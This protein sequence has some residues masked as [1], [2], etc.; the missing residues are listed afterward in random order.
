MPTEAHKD[1][2]V[3]YCHVSSFLKITQQAFGGAQAGSLLALRVT[4]VNDCPR[5]ATKKTSP[6]ELFP[7]FN[8]SFH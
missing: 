6:G 1:Q 7:V 4:D 5:I 2:A 8:V 3:F